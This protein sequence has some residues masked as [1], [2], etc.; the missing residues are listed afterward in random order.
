MFAICGTACASSKR[1]L[2]DLPVCPWLT[3]GRRAL[4]AARRARGHTRDNA[5]MR[6]SHVAAKSTA[7]ENSP[8]MRRRT[9]PAPPGSAAAARAGK[10]PQQ[11]NALRDRGLAM[12]LLLVV[13]GLLALAA[14]KARRAHACFRLFWKKMCRPAN[15]QARARCGPA[16]HTITVAERKT[17]AGSTPRG[18]PSSRDTGTWSDVASRRPSFLGPF[19]R[20]QMVHGDDAKN[21]AESRLMWVGL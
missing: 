3:R 13:G 2:C 15:G 17:P 1:G 7:A 5:R 8:T 19:S 18:V 16:D 6:S 12:G 10:R 4:R 11:R 21:H 9:V 14:S 20:L